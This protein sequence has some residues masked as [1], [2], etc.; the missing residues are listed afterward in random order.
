[1]SSIREANTAAHAAVRSLH[2]VRVICNDLM[3]LDQPMT[4]EQQRQR[5]K[6]IH[7]ALLARKRM[8]L[9]RDRAE[10]LSGALVQFRE[11]QRKIARHA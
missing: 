6:L 3:P 1:M 5:A 9:L 11:R 8:E 7:S 2:A 10:A 4:A